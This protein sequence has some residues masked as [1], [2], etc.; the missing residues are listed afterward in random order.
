VKC[1]CLK[2]SMFTIHVV[3]HFKGNAVRFRPGLILRPFGFLRFRA[4]YTV[5]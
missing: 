4:E 1:G 3:A 2:D 5:K